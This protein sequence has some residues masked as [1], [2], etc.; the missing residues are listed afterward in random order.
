MQRFS[1]AVKL[2]SVMEENALAVRQA[3]IMAELSDDDIEDIF[4]N[5][6]KRLFSN[7]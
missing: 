4:Y 1:S 2:F 6:S 3:A 7:K 5:N